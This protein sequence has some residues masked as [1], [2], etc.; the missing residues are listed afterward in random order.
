MRTYGQFCAVARAL[1][2]VGDRWAL[3][4]VRELLICDRRYG[5]LR[6][7]LPGIATNMLADRLRSLE[8]SG[9][10]ERVEPTPPIATALYRL[11]D[12]GLALDGVLRELARWA[13]PLMATGPGDDQQ[14]GHWLW[15]ALDALFHG[16]DLDGLAPFSVVIDTDDE[17]MRVEFLEGGEMRFD[18]GN[19]LTG[20]VRISGSI[21]DVFDALT[22]PT[23]ARKATVVGSATMLGELVRRAV[24]AR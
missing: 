17:V 21:P 6:A 12:R 14:R 8:A 1:D 20:D 2:V 3:L 9:I 24:D 22:V 23:D 13:F 5:D 19:D 15:L 18:L 4:I 11:T 7:G 16:V 10:V